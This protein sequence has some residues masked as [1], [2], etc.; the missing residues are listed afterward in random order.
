[1][2]FAK[3]HGLGNDYLVLPEV[4][5]GALTAATVARLCDRH[6]GVGGDGILTDES[7]P[8]GAF[9]VRIFNPDGSEAEKS[10]N[11]LRIFA[12]FLWDAGRVGPAP[13][14]VRTAGGTVRCEVRDGGAAVF[15]EMGRATFASERIPVAG[16]T[17]E[18]VAEP[19]DVAGRTLAMTA[20]S[21][22][23][24]HCVVPLDRVS[25][26]LARELGPAIERHPLFP[27]RTNVQLMRVCDRHRIEIEI[28][29]RGA[30]YTLASGSSSCAAAAA[31]VRLGRCTSPIVV[32]MPGG[33]LEIEVGDDWS[34]TMLGPVAK[35]CEG[36]VA[37]EV[38][39]G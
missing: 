4:R 16:P 26:A 29:E 18:V 34:L 15:V 22:G 33:E 31:A 37:P 13:F 39:D 7:D 9:A 30:G 3:Y 35:V 25:E 21:I 20:V 24:P 17:R 38:L 14:E 23:N 11:G 12:R 36:V 6:R 10:G 28:W 1:M 2:R 27:N 19:V 5:G 8:P 32:A